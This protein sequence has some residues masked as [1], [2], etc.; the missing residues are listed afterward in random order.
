MENLV[1]QFVDASEQ[2][3]YLRDLFE[4]LE[5]KP[6]LVQGSRP[7]P[8]PMK[9]GFEFRNVS[10]A[11]PGS[12]K[13]VIQGISFILRP[14]EKIALIGE[15]GAGKTTITKLMA[16]LYD[17]T[18]GQILLDGID[19]CASTTLDDLRREIGVIFQDYMRY[20]MTVSLNIGF[21]KVTDADDRQK[22]E[23][24]AQKSL[25]AGV[26]EKL[27]ERYDQMLGKRFDNGI[28]LSTGQWQKV[29]LARA[30]MSGSTNRLDFG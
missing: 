14:G 13:N 22:I 18:G 7:M 1:G 2:A 21:G 19:L 30:Y 24:S 6:I 25:A 9:G 17:P 11:Y 4:F 26:I 10:F 27:P 16:R 3:L 23:I 15:N 5:A 8:R 28:D 12:K 20:D 29:A